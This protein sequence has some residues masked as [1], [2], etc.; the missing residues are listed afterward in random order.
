MA[1]SRRGWVVVASGHLR[2]RTAMPPL[3]KLR[4]HCSP[5]QSFGV[6]MRTVGGGRS[7]L[8][9]RS[10][11]HT[12]TQRY[13]PYTPIPG[14]ASTSGRREG[15]VCASR[16]VAQAKAR[17]NL[18]PRLCVVDLILTSCVWCVVLCAWCLLH[19]RTSVSL[20]FRLL[21]DG[22]FRTINAGGVQRRVRVIARPQ[23]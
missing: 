3:E 8:I 10:L 5:M 6:A 2:V 7:V 17:S 23:K 15:M 11:I 16:V 20:S 4:A 22:I 18:S 19:P 13:L 14:L 1:T 21:N 12:H 9:D